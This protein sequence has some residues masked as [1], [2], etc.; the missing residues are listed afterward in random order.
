M[1]RSHFGHLKQDLGLIEE[2][3]SESLFN[4]LQEFLTRPRHFFRSQLIPL[5]FELGGGPQ[6]TEAQE[7]LMER[8]GQ[9][10]ESVHAGSL[11]VDDVQDESETRRGQPCLHVEVGVPLALNAGHWLY[12]FA[13]RLIQD[14][15]VAESVKTACLKEMTEAL[16]KAH[17][18]QALDLSVRMSQQRVTEAPLICRQSLEWKAGAL[19]ELGLVLGARIAGCEGPRLNSLRMLGRELGVTLQMFNDLSNLE[20]DEPEEKHLENLLLQRPSYVWWLV[21][22]EFPD[23]WGPF[24]EAV[25]TL[26]QMDSLRFFLDLHPVIQKGRARALGHQQWT[27]QNFATLGGDLTSPAFQKVEALAE[28]IAGSH[29]T[30]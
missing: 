22:E 25:M 17:Q 24:K 1:P 8:A 27:F 14:S 19:L 2:H 23:Q 20:A 7:D 30:N 5:G 21:A 12:F 29:T 11:I 18:G 26:P 16:L 15:E 10:I 4:P 6:P 28:K 13:Y 9:A 3:L